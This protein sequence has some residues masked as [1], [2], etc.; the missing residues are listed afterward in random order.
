MVVM[1]R[2]SAVDVEAL[3]SSA[4]EI[5][6]VKLIAA[7]VPGADRQL[8]GQL[9]DQLAARLQPAAVLLGSVEDGKIAL[10]CK[11]SDDAVTMGAKAGDLISAVARSCG[12]GGGGRP[13][14]AE[15]AGSR[16]EQLDDALKAAAETL[17]S[18][19]E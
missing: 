13:N 10:V 19:L 9:V 1:A 7:A 14:Y 3:A 4:V 8:L 11:V 18:G 16:P 2:G 12:G 15:G 6:G 5:A 17:R